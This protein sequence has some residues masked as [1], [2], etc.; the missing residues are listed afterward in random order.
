MPN[1]GF[2]ILAAISAA[3]TLAVIGYFLYSLQ[4]GP[5]G[6]G[7]IDD[8]FLAVAKCRLCSQTYECE[9]I[10]NVGFSSFGWGKARYQKCR[11]CK[12]LGWSDYVKWANPASTL[13]P[14]H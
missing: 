1:E 13:P 4:R 9:W 11:D 8:R 2:W 3:C 12:K 5:R 6:R 7:E 10:P 14:P